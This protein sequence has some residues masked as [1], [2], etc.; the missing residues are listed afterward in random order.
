MPKPF[1][2]IFPD[3]KR[4]WSCHN[5]HYL[6]KQSVQK[7]FSSVQ[8][9]HSVVSNSLR[10][11]E[12]AHQAS[13][14]ITKSQSSLKLMS[15]KSVM[16]SSH[17]ILCLSHVQLFATPWTV[18]RQAPL[19]LEF[20]RQEYWSSRLPFPTPGD[21]PDP[22]IKPSSPALAGRF[23][24]TELPGKPSRK[25]RESQKDEPKEIHTKINYS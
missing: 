25:Q 10:P 20:S 6:R 22:G 17:L 15:I 5:S 16:P 19:S 2:Y 23:F 24:T 4:S 14:S 8:F 13:L 7:R 21:L 12:S 9:S 11:H 3:S 1:Y 18:A